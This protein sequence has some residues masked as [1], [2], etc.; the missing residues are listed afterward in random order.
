MDSK[1][2]DSILN[3]ANKNNPINIEDNNLRPILGY[4]RDDVKAIMLYDGKVLLTEIGKDIIKKDG[5]DNYQNDLKKHKLTKY[6]LIYLSFFILFGLFGVYKVFQPSVSVSD[7]ENL[8]SDFDSL[9]SRLYSIEKM[10]LK[11]GI[12]QLNDT[13]KSKNSE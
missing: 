12:L 3:L 11:P 2:I 6:Q 9:N 10:K 13:L 7:F 1:K 4:L 5:W 8:K